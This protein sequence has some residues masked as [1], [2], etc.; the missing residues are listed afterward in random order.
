[1]DFNLISLILLTLF[2]GCI[3]G[4]LAGLLGVGGGIVVV[5]LLYYV[6]NY[7]NYDQSII[8]HVAVGSSLLIIVPTSIRS[9]IQH[10][11][12]DS[13][14]QKVFRKWI[15]PLILGTII[16][17]VLA[18]YATFEILTGIFASIATLVSIEM[19]LNRKTKKLKI[20]PSK[21]IFQI[22]PIF[23][24]LV[25]VMMGIGGGSLSVPIM[26]YTGI[27]M[28]KAVGTSAAFG[29]V[30]AIPGSIGFIIGGLGQPLLPP[31]SIGYVNLIAFGLI[32]PATLLTVPIGVNFAHHI[33]QNKLRKLFA[34]FLGV[35]AI[36]MFT[37]LI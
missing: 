10:R 8:M 20:S 19:F 6:L 21:I 12:R 28:R 17:A 16:G 26:N 32:V 33:S 27:E 35:T 9:A 37:D 14:D 24:G 15:A 29:T 11:N 7:L 25:S 31:F 22:A 4:I 5:P 18:S 2:S 36:K 1:M 3:A 30:I 34:L 23:I 13:F